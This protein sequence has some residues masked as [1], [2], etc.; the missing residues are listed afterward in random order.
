MSRE[1]EDDDELQN[2]NILKS[3]GSCGVATPDIPRDSMKKPLRIR[4]VNIGSVENL[5]FA[6]FANVKDNW[7]EET[8]AKIIDLLHEF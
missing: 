7:G 3:K 1:P 2:V 4:K 6:K 8:M 5:K